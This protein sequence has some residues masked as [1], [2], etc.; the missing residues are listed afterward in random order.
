ML[1]LT[2]SFEPAHYTAPGYGQFEC[3]EALGDAANFKREFRPT[4]KQVKGKDW[5]GSLKAVHLCSSL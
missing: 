4:G 3:I 1:E 5:R 2:Q